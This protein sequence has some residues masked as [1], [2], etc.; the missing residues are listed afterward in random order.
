MRDAVRA[1]DFNRSS[2]WGWHK[3]INMSS[4]LLNE[5]KNGFMTSMIMVHSIAST[6]K[7]LCAELSVIG[8]NKATTREWLDVKLGY[9]RMWPTS[10][11]GCKAKAFLSFVKF[12]VA[13]IIPPKHLWK[14]HC[15]EHFLCTQR[16]S[17]QRLKILQEASADTSVMWKTQKSKPYFL[18]DESRVLWV[19]DRRF[20][21]EIQA[22][23]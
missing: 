13:Y 21:K 18:I 12:I 2:V 3:V 14:I 16:R 20:S 15:T 9:S 8:P 17:W 4:L 22:Y 19:T 1:N 6:G 7:L 11:L 5:A 23:C 10:E